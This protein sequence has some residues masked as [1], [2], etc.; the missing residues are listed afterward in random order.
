MSGASAVIEQFIDAIN[1]Q[2]IGRAR[3]V[4][5]SDATMRFPGGNTFTDVGA[6]IEW[7]KGRYRRAVYTY[8]SLEQLV[9]AGATIVYARGSIA[10]ELNDGESF[11]GVRVVDRYTIENGL[12]RDKEAWSDMADYLRRKGS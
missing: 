7:T 6:F 12:I 11:Q 3:K 4:M 5:T 10:G 1:R 9:I 2:D 8:D